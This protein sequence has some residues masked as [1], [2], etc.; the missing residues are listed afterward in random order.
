MQNERVQNGDRS[1][2]VQIP[3]FVA[4]GIETGRTRLHAIEEQ[5]HGLF[6]DLKSRGNRELE[7]IKERLPDVSIRDRVPVEDLV[8]RA[9]NVETETRERAEALA[10]D[11]E[12]KAVG[13]Q[14]SILAL[15]GIASRDQVAALARDL[16]RISRR[17]DRVAKQARSADKSKADQSAKGGRSKSTASSSTKR[18]SATKASPKKKTSSAKS[19]N[20]RRPALG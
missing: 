9:K 13:L 18:K 14:D 5:A 17:L 2:K 7:A 10:E 12:R 11:V 19:R 6:N 4:S 3:S 20:K 16:D 8:D 15:A 1:S